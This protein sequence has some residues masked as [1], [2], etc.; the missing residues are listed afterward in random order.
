M[1]GT[2]KYLLRH[3]AGLTK[4]DTLL[5]NKRMVKSWM[6]DS[7]VPEGASIEAKLDGE[8]TL[9]IHIDIT[10]PVREAGVE[11]PHEYPLKNTGVVISV[12]KYTSKI[13][14]IELTCR[15]LD[16]I[17][18]VINGAVGRLIVEYKDHD[19]PEAIVKNVNICLEL[20]IK[21]AKE[22]VVHYEGQ[23]DESNLEVA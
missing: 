10:Y 5:V 14:R 8:N 13:L 11:P 16:E 6:D 2:N 3:E 17:V 23:K 9:S 22:I 12:G 15:K 4:E 1:A 21:V 20:L 19:Y 18:N 7:I